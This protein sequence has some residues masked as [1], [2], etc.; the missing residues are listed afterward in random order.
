MVSSTLTNPRLG[1]S[2]HTI[3]IISGILIVMVGMIW[4]RLNLGA[5]LRKVLVWS[6]LYMGFMNWFATL[7]GAIS[8]ASMLTPIAG[9]GTSGTPMYENIVFVLFN[10]VAL[11]SFVG[12]IIILWG[13]RGDNPTETD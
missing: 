2:A 11:A 1:L 5:T 8:G 12:V 10:T 3:A 4:D 7:L 6:W 13:L 9:A